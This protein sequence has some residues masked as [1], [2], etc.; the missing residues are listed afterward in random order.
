[1]SSYRG[2]RFESR[3]E[4]RA[5]PRLPGWSMEEASLVLTCVATCRGGAGSSQ[6]PCCSGG[7]VVGL[8]WLCAASTSLHVSPPCGSLYVS[9]TTRHA[10]AAPVGS[11][12]VAGLGFL[13]RRAV[14][15]TLPLGLH[16]LRV[17]SYRPHALERH[18]PVAEDATL[19]AP[20]AEAAMLGDLVK[21]SAFVGVAPPC[22][23]VCLR[24]CVSV[25]VSWCHGVLGGG[26]G[27]GLSASAAAL[28]GLPRRLHAECGSVAW[29]PARW[30]CLAHAAAALP[31]AV[32]PRPKLATSIA[33]FAVVPVHVACRAH[34]VLPLRL[35]CCPQ[36]S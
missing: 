32:D 27:P 35:R 15:C 24:V 13:Q 7:G 18:E 29:S 5:A 26:S 22:V 11:A 12:R 30:S 3:F 9:C 33:R 28:E 17:H 8:C 6:G 36:R 19:Y 4:L 10:A 23:R 34:Q 20:A 2:P 25:L 14:E 31:A 21:G 1:M 16:L